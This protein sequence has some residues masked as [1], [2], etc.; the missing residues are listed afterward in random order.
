MGGMASLINGQECQQ[1]P[2]DGKAT[3][4]CHA[5]PYAQESG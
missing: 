2:R 5:A 1:I 4:V 3:E